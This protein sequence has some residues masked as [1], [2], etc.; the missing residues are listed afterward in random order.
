MCREVIGP[1]VREAFACLMNNGPP[2]RAGC[3]TDAR[4]PNLL[5]RLTYLMVG[6]DLRM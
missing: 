3:A 1:R 6:L 5:Y 4:D 2:T